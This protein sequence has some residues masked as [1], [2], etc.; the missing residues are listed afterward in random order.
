V[1]NIT[2]NLIASAGV[3]VD[4]F[5]N[6]GSLDITTNKY[7]GA[8][9]QTAFSPKFGLVYQPIKNVVSIFGNYQNG[10]TNKTGT[11][12]N[13]KTFK[14]EH[15]TQW[16]GG[17]KVAAMGGRL[18]GTVSYYD[19]KV[20]DMIRADAQHPNFSIQDGTQ[21]SKGIEVDVN[22]NPAQG[23]NIIAGFAYNDSKMAEADADVQGRRPVTAGSP[24]LGNLWIGYKVPQGK[25]QG[26][27]LGFGGNYASDNKIVNSVYY[28]VFTLPAYTIL[29]ASVFYEATKF[30]VGLKVDNLTNKEYWTG[31]TT[32]NPQKLR[33]ITG[34]I[35]FK[36]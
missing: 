34:S 17:V 35:S 29:N 21:V 36:F 23:L 25:L 3:R 28:G 26:L 5:D 14:P 8:Y 1:I 33:S 11:D 30:R 2:D 9:T 13:G 18:T 6:K 15:A 10:F 12:V 24:Y 27:G 19:I 31:Y 22:A 20:K 16:E 7:T 4:Y 32:M